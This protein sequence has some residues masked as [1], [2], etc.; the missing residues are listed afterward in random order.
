MNLQA[1]IDAMNDSS[2]KERSK[3]HLTLG[4]LIKI[5]ES[6]PEHFPIKF[7]DD[8][9]PSNPH[10]Y[11]GY[12]SDLA[13]EPD[14]KE[15]IAKDFLKLCQ[16]SLG[17]IFTGYKGGDFI[18]NADTPLWKADEGCCGGEAIVD[19]RIGGGCVILLTKEVG[20]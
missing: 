11:R 16:E 18:M 7:N 3:Y 4:Q 20:E 8:T 15:I 17:E 2:Q 14:S 12:Y 9:Y 13:F 6:L 5:L 1:L 19:W 10:S